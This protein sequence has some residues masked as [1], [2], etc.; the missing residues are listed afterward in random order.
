MNYPV[1]PTEDEL[2]ELS[3]ILGGLG[4]GT[5]RSPGPWELH[6][7]EVWTDPPNSRWRIILDLQ[8]EI[9]HLKELALQ[10]KEHNPYHLYMEIRELEQQEARLFY[11]YTYG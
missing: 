5:S 3:F 9:A 10:Y 7:M 4:H 11:W 1:F 8:E 2:A 6:D